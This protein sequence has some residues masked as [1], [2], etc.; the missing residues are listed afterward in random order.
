MNTTKNQP[1]GSARERARLKQDLAERRRKERKIL[2]AAVLVLVLVVGG[3]IG[4]QYWRTHRAPSAGP[5]G[6]SVEFAPVTVEPEKPLVLGAEGAPVTLTVFSDFH[7]PHCAQ[8][9]Q[10]FGETIGDKQRDGTVALEVYSMAF[11]DEGSVNA[12]NAMACAAEDGFGQEYYEGLWANA[13]RAWTPDQLLELADQLD[14]D[15]GG[16]FS[17]CVTGMGHQDWV[18]SMDA[19]SEAHGVEGTP[20]VFL[21]GEL[22]ALDGLSPQDLADRIDS[23]AT[24]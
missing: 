6:D 13:D 8:F 7:C 1:S 23:A 19:A 15:A 3:G 16:D 14:V 9:E 10:M 20:T 11:M 2:I 17:S 12:A 21:D 4:F 22:V 18:E 5:G 24:K